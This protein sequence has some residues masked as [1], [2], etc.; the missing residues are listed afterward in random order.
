MRGNADRNASL[1]I[2]QRLVAR[3]QKSGQEK[4]QA[5]LRA[6]RVV[7]AAGGSVSQDAK[8]EEEPSF[9]RSRHADTTEHG[10]AQERPLRM[11]ERLSDIPC[12]LRSPCE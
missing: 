8:S 6:E 3:Y 9:P 1:V 11:D 7:K 4:P 5:P 12:Q 10:T 2:G